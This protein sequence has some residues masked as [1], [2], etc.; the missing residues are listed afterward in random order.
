[1]F[2]RQVTFETPKDL[3]DILRSLLNPDNSQETKLSLLK[4]VNPHSITTEALATLLKNGAFDYFSDLIQKIP[5]GRRPLILNTPASGGETLLTL[6]SRLTIKDTTPDY[7]DD[8][9]AR[10]LGEL[11]AAGADINLKD[12]DGLTALICSIHRKK[13]EIC[14]ILLKHGAD[15]TL[16]AGNGSIPIFLFLIEMDEFPLEAIQNLRLNEDFILRCFF[17]VVADDAFLP[18][19]RTK[20]LTTLWN[21]FPSL[22]ARFL[23]YRVQ[24]RTPL[25]KAAEQSENIALCMFLLSHGADPL[26][27]IEDPSGALPGGAVALAVALANRCKVIVMSMIKLM[28]LGI[29]KEALAQRDAQNENAWHILFSN[30]AFYYVDLLKKRLDLQLKG[31][32]LTGK[33]KVENQKKLSEVEALLSQQRDDAK[34]TLEIYQ[35]IIQAL[36]EG[37]AVDKDPLC[38]YYQIIYFPWSEHHEKIFSHPAAKAMIN[39][40]PTYIPRPLIKFL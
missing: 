11:I 22:R 3:K 16:T 26:A 25:H 20:R 28:P 38:L 6:L 10:Y 29:L 35:V 36:G 4:K 30:F 2:P 7:H 19:E 33:A 21:L 24:G 5:E 40:L 8:I 31:L 15:V 13:P 23:S 32:S 17:Q 14:Q 27:R 9:I 1:M 34:K 12:A 39:D 18:A 37:Y